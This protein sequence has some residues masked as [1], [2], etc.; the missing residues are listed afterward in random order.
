MVNMIIPY[1]QNWCHI[2]SMAVL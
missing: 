1:M 2:R